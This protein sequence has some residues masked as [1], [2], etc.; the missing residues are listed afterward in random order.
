MV[1]ALAGGLVAICAVAWGRFGGPVCLAWV[2]DLIREID[3][4]RAE[5]EARAFTRAFE[6]PAA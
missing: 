2:R 5:T 4:A 6:G 3:P 1:E